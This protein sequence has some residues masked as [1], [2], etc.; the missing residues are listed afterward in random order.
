MESIS[1]IQTNGRVTKLQGSLNRADE[2]KVLDALALL[3]PENLNGEQIRY[4]TFENESQPR[5]FFVTK[6]NE[7]QLLALILEPGS[8]FLQAR[9]LAKT[10][11]P[12]VEPHSEEASVVPTLNDILASPAAPGIAPQPDSKWTKTGEKDVDQISS[13]QKG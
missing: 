4:F 2:Q 5:L 8:S 13:E 3:T 7:T 10:Y 11:L 1:Y 9:R 12:K 6:I